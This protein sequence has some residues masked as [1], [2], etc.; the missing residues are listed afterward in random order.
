MSTPTIFTDRQRAAVAPFVRAIR[1]LDAE[2][3]LP[4]HADH[5]QPALH[6]DVGALLAFLYAFDADVPA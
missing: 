2:R 4:G 6:L 1:R 5:M 3:A